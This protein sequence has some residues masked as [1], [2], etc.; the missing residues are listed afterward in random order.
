MMTRCTPVVFSIV[1][2]LAAQLIASPLVATELPADASQITSPFAPVAIVNNDIITQFDVENRIKFVMATGGSVTNEQSMKV[3]YSEIVQTLI[4]EQLQMQ[5]AERFKI[6][7]A[8]E[9]INAAI[10]GIEKERGKPKGSLVGYLESNAIPF[11]T[12]KRQ[13]ESQLAWNKLLQKNVVSDI[14]VSSAEMQR[15]QETETQRLSQ[16]Q[17]VKL[18]SVIIPAGNAPKQAEELAQN[19]SKSIRAG[20]ALN[21]VAEQYNLPAKAFVPPAWVPVKSI[22]PT[23]KTIIDNISDESGVS[24]AVLTPNGYQV[25]MVQEKRVS[26]YSKDAEMLFKDI[27]LNLSEGANKQEVD[28][29]ME[30]ARSLRKNPGECSGNTVGGADSLE[31]L[32]FTVDFTRLQLSSLSA[33]IKPLVRNLSVGEITEPF[34]T[35]IGIKMLKLCERVDKPAEH[36]HDETLM[37][38]ALKEEKFK[39]KAV[40]YLRD[41]RSKAFVDIKI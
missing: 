28:L 12:L 41:L 22:A 24:D 39:A 21:A 10:E 38:T 1:I 3:L 2:A 9:E 5:E 26:D 23:I 13:I 4:N 32:D 35:P 18:A 37:K 20:K 19:I 30:I 31:G 8:D 33:Q 34:A 6:T 36:N 15:M 29:L 17:E 25:I 16:V 40:K 27:T 14:S 7:I 11:E